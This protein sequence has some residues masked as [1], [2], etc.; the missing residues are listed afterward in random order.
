[1]DFESVLENANKVHQL[2]DNSLMKFVMAIRNA[3]DG[4]WNLHIIIAFPLA[5][6][7]LKI[8]KD[9]F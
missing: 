4:K 9:G 7:S 5:S 3:F 8:L 6:Q 2:I 1:M